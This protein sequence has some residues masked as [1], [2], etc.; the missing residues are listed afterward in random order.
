MFKVDLS[1]IAWF[2]QVVWEL[3]TGRCL[4]DNGVAE[5]IF[6]NKVTSSTVTAP[7]KA[8]TI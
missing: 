5:S 7:D 4:A 8:I 1:L 6:R 3:K 2:L